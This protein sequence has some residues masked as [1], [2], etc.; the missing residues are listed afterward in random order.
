MASR[1]KFKAN[2]A[3]PDEMGNDPEFRQ[4]LLGNAVAVRKAIPGNLPSG[5]HGGR[6][7]EPFAEK[8]FA[9]IEGSG[10][11]VHCLVGTKWRVGP[12]IEFGSRNSPA[13]APVR[14]SAMQSGL[15][16]VRN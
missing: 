6:R 4:M 12:I 9:E 11:D 7:V 16:F 8:S 2:P 13:Y 10:R 15:R 3:F 5:A 1:I 14:K